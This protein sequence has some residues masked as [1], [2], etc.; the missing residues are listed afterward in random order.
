M[1][2]P[3]SE[4]IAKLP[5]WAQDHIENLSRQRKAAVAELDEFVAKH[6]SGAV[7]VRLM[8]SDN[9]GGPTQRQV[10]FDAHWLEIQ[11][12][13]IKLDITLAEGELRLAYAD[14]GNRR[15]AVHFVPTSHQQFAL[16]PIPEMRR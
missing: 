13:G 11:H 6:E 14:R 4:Q 3:T 1:N 10:R 16:R 15:D 8:T 7:A 12:E 9:D 2:A 5:K